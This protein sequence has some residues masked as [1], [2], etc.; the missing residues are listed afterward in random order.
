MRLRLL[1]PA[2][3]LLSSTQAL[4]SSPG[5]AVQAGGSVS[6]PS[7]RSLAR[8]VPVV[9]SPVK[10]AAAAAATLGA[11]CG[12][13]YACVQTSGAPYQAAIAALGG[14]ARVLELLAASREAVGGD[15][16]A[17]S[18][19]PELPP[20]LMPSVAATLLLFAV[21]VLHA[22]YALGGRWSARWLAATHY[23]RCPGAAATAAL[24]LPAVRE[25][26]VVLPIDDDKRAFVHRQRTY[27]HDAD[28]DA[29]APEAAQWRSP[30]PPTDLPLAA[31]FAAAK[32]DA[33]PP[34]DAAAQYGPNRIDVPKP[35]YRE[36]LLESVLSPL[37]VRCCCCRQSH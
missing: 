23:R 15:G 24:V 7:G 13:A 19:Y 27:T 37:S 3:L 31:Y 17:A 11:Y 21:A 12:A 10:R 26:W 5:S 30:S 34:P 14:E 6:R 36:A 33:S 29:D 35:L 8:V 9:R 20:A 32:S 16:T 25:P 28:A 4:P 1:V 2:L 18:C 22:L